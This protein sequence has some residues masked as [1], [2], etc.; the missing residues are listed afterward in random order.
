MTKLPPSYYYDKS[1]D[2]VFSIKRKQFLP[3][4]LAS[5]WQRRTRLPHGYFYHP[6]PLHPEAPTE[7]LLCKTWVF[8]KVVGYPAYL[9]TSFGRLFRADGTSRRGVSARKDFGAF[10][11]TLFR[12]GSQDYVRL[13]G[14]DG[15]PKVLRLKT[16]LQKT[17]PEVHPPED[18][19]ES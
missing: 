12:R 13:Q 11:P 7:E 10:H 8:R 4:C 17:W 18:E 19:N 6:S 1:Q 9:V 5:K 16:I 14:P 3:F 2:L 15:K